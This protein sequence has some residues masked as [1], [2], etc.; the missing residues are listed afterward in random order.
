MGA[1]SPGILAQ[2]TSVKIFF[3]WAGVMARPPILRIQASSSLTE[4]ALL[5]T[6]LFS[7]ALREVVMDDFG[8]IFTEVFD[9]MGVNL[10]G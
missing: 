6:E 5:G 1:D 10:S 2:R 8:V 3:F 9:R 4:D 7:T